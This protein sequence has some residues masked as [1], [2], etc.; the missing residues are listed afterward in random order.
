M[1]LKHTYQSQSRWIFSIL[2]LVILLSLQ[3]FGQV[4][5][6]W[7]KSHLTSTQ[8]SYIGTVNNERGIGYGMVNSNP[9]LYVATVTGGAKAVILNATTG[10]SVGTLSGTG[11]SGGTFTLTDVDVSSD[12]V[13][14]GC[15]LV[16][17][18]AVATP[19]KIYKWTSES[20]DPVLVATW[21]TGAYRLGDKFT[22]V[23]S[24]TDNSITIYAAA[25]SNNKF[26]KFT[27]TDNG[28]TFTGT[29]VV[30]TGLS[31]GTSASITPVNNGVDGYWIKGGGANLRK[32]N[33]DYTLKTVVHADYAPTNGNAV[34]YFTSGSRKFLA[35][36]QSGNATA[37]GTVT[38]FYERIR[39][40][41]V[42]NDSVAIP[43]AQT[44]RLGTN[45]NSNA[46][47]DVAVKD[48]GNGTFTIYGFSTNNGV[49]AYT[50]D[51]ATASVNFDLN[52]TQDF[53]DAWIP[54]GW[55]RYTGFLN[56]NPMAVTSGTWIPD[57]FGNVTSPINRAARINI[58]GTSIRHLMVSPTI[59]LGT[60]T[61]T[62]QVEFDLA[63]TLYN[64]TTSAT[65]GV[66]DTLA[67]V[68]STDNGV[69]WNPA[70]IVKVYNSTTPIL[71]TGQT[72]KVSLSGYSGLVKIGFYAASTVSNAD[73]DL[74]IDNFK[75]TNVPLNPVYAVNP[76]SKNFG[77][78][79]VGTTSAP[80]VFTI[81]NSGGGDLVVSSV[82]LSGDDASSFVKTD[83]NNYPNTIPNGQSINL[84]VH[85]APT[86]VG[87]KSA[88]LIISHNATGGVDTV[89]LSGVAN[90]Y[91][92]NTFPYVQNFDSSNGVVP[93]PGWVNPGSYWTRG[94]EAK[95]LPY[96]AR[97][98]YNHTAGVG[99]AILQTPLVNLPANSK[100]TF[101]WKD[102]DITAG[103]P[104]PVQKEDENG[105]TFMYYPPEPEIAGHDTTFFE[106]SVDN[107]ANWTTLGFL[108][109]AAAQAAYVEASFD[110]SAYAGNGRLFRWRDVTNASFSAYGAGLDDIVIE[111]VPQVTMDWHN[112]Q[113]PPN[114]QIMAGGTVTVYTKGWE[115]GVTSVPGPDTTISVWIGV[116]T[117]NTNPNTWT[118]WIP[119]VYNEQQGND[120]EYK[121]DIG[122]GLVPGT[123]YYASRW[124]LQ[125]GPYTYG[126]YNAGGGGF[127]DGTNNVSG[128]LTVTPYTVNQFPY[129]ES[130][131][132]TTFPPNGWVRQDLNAGSTWSRSTAAPRTGLASAAYTYSG[133]LPGNDWLITPGIQMQVGKTYI[134]NYWYRVAGAAYPE[135]MKVAVG[136]AQL[137]DS[138]TTVLF[139]HGN[140]T[141]AVYDGKNLYYT[142]S[143]TGTYYFGFHV[144][145]LAD[146]WNLYLDDVT[147]NEVPEI[148]YAVG[149]VY[150]VNGIPTP[151]GVV[152][153][154]GFDKANETEEIKINSVGIPSSE[155][156]NSKVILNA[157]PDEFANFF[158]NYTPVNL[159]ALVYNQGVQALQYTLNYNIA[160]QAGTPINGSA[161]LTGAVDT[162]DLVGTPSARGTFTSSAT[163]TVAGDTL[164]G[165]D[166]FEFFRT[167]VYP[168][169]NVRLRYDNGSHVPQTF[170]GFGTNNI[171][172]Y[173]AVRFTATEDMKLTNVDAFYRN[174]SNTDSI[175]VRILAKGDTT[176]APGAL[177]Y[178][179]KF[180]G[181]N[182]LVPG[183]G[184][185]YVTLPLGDDAPIMLAGTDFWINIVY[186]SAVQFPLGVHNSGFTP[187]RSF[188]S[189]D[190]GATWVPLVV[191]T[192]RAWLI[193]T[194]GT[195]YVAPVPPFDTLWHASA[196]FSNLPSWYSASGSTERGFAYGK[197]GGNDRLYVVSRN[198]GLSV[199]VLNANT[200]ADVDT[201]RVNGTI[202][203]GGTFVINDAEVSDDGKVFAANLTTNA[204]TSPFKV[205][206]WNTETAEPEL[207][208]NYTGTEAVRLGDKFTVSGNFFAGTA[209][210]W[211][212]SATTGISK[213][214][215]WTMNAGMFNP[216]PEVITLSDN[217]T[218]GSAQV[219]PMPNGDFYFN[220]TGM[221]PKKYSANGT[222]VGTVPGSVVATGSNG[223]K[224]IGTVATSEF[225]V[226]FAFGGG[227]ENARIIEIPNGVPADA[228][229]YGVTPSLGTNSNANGTGDVAIKLNSDL[230]ADIFVLSTNNG[231]GAYSTSQAVPVEFATFSAEAQDRNVILMWKTSTETNSA[232]FE[233]ERTLSSAGSWSTVGS[234]RASGTTTETKSYSFVDR[235]L[236]SAKYQYRLKQ[237]DLD[238]TYSYSNVI[239]VE[240]GLPVSFD[241]SQN[242]PNPF[243]PTTRIAYQIPADSRV[244]MELY[245]ITGQKVATLVNTELTAG[246]YT[247]DL[248]VGSYGLASGVYIYRM[249]AVEKA[250]GKNFVNT[251]KMMML[252]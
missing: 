16:T 168:S 233:V 18:T 172:L 131:E 239:E 204:S 25:A 126:G 142:P 46:T 35:I 36:Y 109:A 179:K 125:N 219:A 38:S 14:F 184:G 2:T 250:S 101:W 194:V 226:T 138:L 182:Y 212:A 116:S 106:V 12:G 248:S 66:D 210:I 86:T 228:I 72:E 156:N 230:T 105:N 143:S 53:A 155:V 135:K 59:D 181:N 91:T 198:G 207:A 56:G 146:Q 165:N 140:I 174:E 26:V 241:M 6:V 195:P 98:I 186:P 205:Y 232:S 208:L 19:F 151:F 41:E 133:T 32:I 115:N 196:S 224:F 27:T 123:Y 90:D 60:G 206:M 61:P 149:N 67:V 129:T 154:T 187:G 69:S 211:A 147:I 52:S 164:N 57:D 23:G 158:E 37:V 48:N 173:A 88:S 161:I 132:S 197:V 214:Y 162:V 94:T 44:P 31:S 191:T 80:Q 220:A 54:Y 15:N 77:E 235:D 97:V 95:S 9:R 148:D 113:W 192:E 170:V 249:T 51:P 121:A 63:L 45:A 163:V 65:L 108:S 70:N 247:F 150:Q 137:A 202:I 244:T 83:I 141:N 171:K 107:G 92:I 34:R 119:A 222:L 104:A 62:K 47:G 251:K 236:V 73:N 200:G 49:G 238:G 166:T 144:Y 122:T 8:P 110:L 231:I 120:D 157:K 128:V 139:D 218:G 76:G 4:S 29:E 85:F 103:R 223:I 185:A 28:A 145:S 180:A 13:I 89:E 216:V 78:L 33:A 81:S 193:R 99:G 42:V 152:S 167:L 183:T 96:A 201:L 1:M 87:S 68:V 252:K 39:I 11:I 243:N 17:S 93:P 20:A 118:T 189:Q 74:F 178:S 30:A 136:N 117:S 114:A 3:V 199:R 130:F 221:N 242:Y 245:D 50:F 7:E 209:A 58:Y 240:V 134:L 124:Q 227:N 159:K 111:E 169:N 43:L 100:I 82:T 75:I 237:I 217:V 213:V 22:V 55:T 21:E 40:L 229:V 215:K 112:L 176:L 246:Y 71:N 160:G 79:Q 190:S 10:D 64:A 127:W 84:S 175:E 203:S 188:L 102:D 24:T 225:F 5:T 234:V 177:L 153:N